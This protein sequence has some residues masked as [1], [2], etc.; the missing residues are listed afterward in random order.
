MSA[1]PLEAIFAMNNPRPP[2]GPDGPEQAASSAIR[3]AMGADQ[4]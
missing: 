2:T 4:E 3:R 1:R